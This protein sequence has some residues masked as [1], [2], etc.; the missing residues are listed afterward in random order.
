MTIKKGSYL[1]RSDFVKNV[2]IIVLGKY[3]YNGCTEVPFTEVTDYLSVSSDSI[4]FRKKDTKAMT[5]L[6]KHGITVKKIKGIN[7]FVLNDVQFYLA[8]E[9]MKMIQS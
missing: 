1:N 2:C 5:M 6:E 4:R 9:K 7:H 8:I 3:M